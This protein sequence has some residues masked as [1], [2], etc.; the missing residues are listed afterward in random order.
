MDFRV[1]DKPRPFDAIRYASRLV[2]PRVRVYMQVSKLLVH[3][4]NDRKDEPFFEIALVHESGWNR[5]SNQAVHEPGLKR[6]NSIHGQS[7]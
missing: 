4:V 5:I 1:R 3:T 7:G 2:F 6:F